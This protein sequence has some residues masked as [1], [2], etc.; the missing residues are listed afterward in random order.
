MPANLP[1]SR[2]KRL[3]SQLAR[4]V[5]TGADRVETRPGRSSPITVKI[6]AAI[7][8]HYEPKRGAGERKTQYPLRR[9]GFPSSRR[10]PGETAH[11]RRDGA[12]SRRDG[13][14]SRRDGAHSRRDG[15]DS[16]TPA[17]RQSNVGRHA[18]VVDCLFDYGLDLSA[19][20]SVATD[21]V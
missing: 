5:L 14:D 9:R 2:E 19:E 15:A 4:C 13:A 20:L 8:A 3:R 18:F 16:V 7:H 11:P 12:D 21:S 10:I 1:A 6:K 17:V